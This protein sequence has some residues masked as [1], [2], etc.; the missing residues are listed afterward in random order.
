MDWRLNGLALLCLRSRVGQII[1][2]CSLGIKQGAVRLRTGEDEVR[3]ITNEV[4]VVWLKMKKL[5]V[6]YVTTDKKRV[7][8]KMLQGAAAEGKTCPM[9]IPLIFRSNLVI[10]FPQYMTFNDSK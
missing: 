2:E 8:L 1:P 7:L 10:F 5:R 6:M 9:I 4:G 3:E